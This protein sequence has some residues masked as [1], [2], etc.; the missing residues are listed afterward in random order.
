MKLIVLHLGSL[1]LAITSSTNIVQRDSKSY[2]STWG[3]PHTPHNRDEKD[4]HSEEKAPFI[5]LP[6]SSNNNNNIYS[7]T[8]FP[9]NNDWGLVEV[10]RDFDLIADEFADKSDNFV[11]TQTENP[12]EFIP[13]SRDPWRAVNTQPTQPAPVID[14]RLFATN[15]ENTKLDFTWT[16]SNSIVLDEGGQENDEEVYQDNNYLVITSADLPKEHR[17]LDSEINNA[18]ELSDIQY[19]LNPV[20]SPAPVEPPTIFS[21]TVQ[22][23]P[24][25]QPPTNLPP[26]YQPPPLQPV[27][28]SIYPPKPAPAPQTQ[29]FQ[30]YIPPPA[31]PPPPRPVRLA[32]APPKPAAP[33]P[34]YPAV[35]QPRLPKL[36]QS[37]QAIQAAPQAQHGNPNP[38]KPRAQNE[39]QVTKLSK[40]PLTRL[41]QQLNIPNPAD[42]A[43]PSFNEIRQNIKNVLPTFPTLP[44]IPTFPTAPPRQ[45]Y[46]NSGNS[47]LKLPKIPTILGTVVPGILRPGTRKPWLLHSLSDSLVSL[48]SPPA[49]SPPATY[50]G[51]AA[52]VTEAPLPLPVPTYLPISK[53][54]E[55]SSGFQILVQYIFAM[56]GIALILAI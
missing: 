22:T 49:S 53:D 12:L 44:T 1:G 38:P 32:T 2:S 26:P 55:F 50:S 30:D 23:D 37:S 42:A 3:S 31:Y 36:S 56:V 8:D 24:Q 45:G 11:Y 33:H 10:D 27:H 20:V 14:D 46:G 9:Q 48:L 18:T 6:S 35:V 16:P 17:G 41:K 19:G 21:N 34:T 47:G 29:Q 39:P 43:L 15:S 13:S 5:V 54:S 51:A 40:N 7:L 25:P 28:A 4:S 52:A